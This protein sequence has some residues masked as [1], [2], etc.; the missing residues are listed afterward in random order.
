M[1]FMKL[2]KGNENGKELILYAFKFPNL[3]IINIHTNFKLQTSAL[4]LL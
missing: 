2:F 1:P 4:L 3:L